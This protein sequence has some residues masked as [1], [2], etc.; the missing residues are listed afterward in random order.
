MGLILF[1]FTPM[2]VQAASRI[3]VPA[4]T[5]KNRFVSS[6]GLDRRVG[7]VRWILP[8]QRALDPTVFGTPASPLGFEPDVGV[9]VAGRII[10]NGAFTTNLGVTPFSNNFKNIRGSYELWLANITLNDDP[11]SRDWEYFKAKF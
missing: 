1:L 3:P 10:E 4:P 6:W 5:L 2:L 8:G 7:D 11:R 9:P